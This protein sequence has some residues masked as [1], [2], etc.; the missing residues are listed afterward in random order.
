[1]SSNERRLNTIVYI[2]S[3]TQSAHRFAKGQPPF[4]FEAESTSEYLMAMCMPFIMNEDE[5]Y[6]IAHKSFLIDMIN[7]GW[8]CGVEDFKN[9]VHPDLV[10]YKELS[11]DSKAMVAFFGA[12]TC[13]AQDFYKNFKADV[14]DE[15]MDSFKAPIPS[16]LSVR[17]LHQCYETH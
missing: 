12:L 17:S 2:L 15:F 1:M 13:S 5:D 8:T 11:P 10:E 6:E 9:R 4:D 16:M 14:E 7:C 3:L